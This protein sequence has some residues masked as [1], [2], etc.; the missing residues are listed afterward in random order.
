[1]ANLDLLK[2]LQIGHANL[3]F[4]P[5]PTDGDVGG[6]WFVCKHVE[7]GPNGHRCCFVVPQRGSKHAHHLYWP[8]WIRPFPDEFTRGIA[9]CLREM[10]VKSV[11]PSGGEITMTAGS[12]T[13]MVSDVYKLMNDA[14]SHN[15]IFDR[16]V[17]TINEALREMALPLSV[18][19]WDGYPLGDLVEIAT[20]LKTEHIVVFREGEDGGA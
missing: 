6:V 19:K 11:V 1:M 12:V 17:S 2:P 20:R 18:G 16:C 3:N 4:E 5:S 7:V 13:A 14:Y 10:T 15:L 9:C 8:Q